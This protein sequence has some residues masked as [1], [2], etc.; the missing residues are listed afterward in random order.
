[1]QAVAEGYR[2]HLRVSSAKDVSHDDTL[3]AR[4]TVEGA[5]ALYQCFNTEASII[6]STRVDSMGDRLVPE[7]DT[8]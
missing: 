6:E 5:G 7:L 8:K 1:M 3:A 4:H 2:C